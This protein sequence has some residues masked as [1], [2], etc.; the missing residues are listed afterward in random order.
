MN[1]CTTGCAGNTVEEKMLHQLV[2]SLSHYLQGFR[3]TRW[4]RISSINS[5]NAPIFLSDL[6]ISIATSKAPIGEYGRGSGCQSLKEK[7]AK[8]THPSLVPFC[9]T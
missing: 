1:Q 9:D 2:D 8:R 7:K 4:C 5:T 3:H 6:G